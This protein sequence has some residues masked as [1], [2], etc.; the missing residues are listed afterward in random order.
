MV[1]IL[2]NKND[3]NNLELI[4]LNEINILK[5]TINSLTTKIDT[6]T[7]ESS[8]LVEEY[9]SILT[10]TQDNL[11]DIKLLKKDIELNIRAFN[12]FEQEKDQLECESEFLIS[13]FNKFEAM[14]SLVEKILTQEIEIAL[15]Y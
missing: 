9:Y 4:K 2:D 1:I 8:S 5:S 3:C 10:S 14:S 7:K 12:I 6:L 13:D 11:K 15:E